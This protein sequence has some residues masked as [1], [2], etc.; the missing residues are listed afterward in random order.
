MKA[1]EAPKPDIAKPAESSPVESKPAESKSKAKILSLL[2][3]TLGNPLAP[4]FIT[5]FF[6]S[7]LIVWSICDHS[8]PL[9]DAS[10]HSTYSSAVKKW[11]LRPRIWS[12]ESLCE[13]LRMQPNYPA[14]TWFFNGFC[15]IFLGDSLFSEHLILAVHLCILNAASFCIANLLLKDRFKASLSIIFLDCSPLIQ[16]L[17]HLSYIDL[18]HTAFFASYLFSLIY[19]W[20]K[21]SWKSAFICGILFG[22]D[23]A[24]KQIAVLYS[25]P[26]LGVMALYLLYARQYRQLLQLML[27]GAFAPLF[28][29]SWVI[30]NW[31]SLT[32]YTHN[33]SALAYER[34]GFV[35]GLT[36]N[37]SM[38]FQQIVESFSPLASL[39]L[40]LTAFK[41]RR[42]GFEKLWIPV[43][44]ASAGVLLL[45]SV[46][47]FNLPEP[48]YFGPVVLALSLLLGV[49]CG[50]LARQS[51]KAAVFVSAF[52]ALLVTQT[53]VLS[54]QKCP[55][56]SHPV[57][58]NL[59]PLFAFAGLH[60][61][62]LTC[63]IP[64]L[65]AGDPWKQQ[66]LF[67]FIENTERKSR[68]VYLSVLDNSPE[69]NQGVLLCISRLRK[70]CVHPTT[71]RGCMPD[72]KDSFSC[73]DEALNSMQW[74]LLKTGPQHSAWFDDKSR[75]NYEHS[76]DKIKND[77]VYLEAARQLLP[78]GAELVLYQ[79]KRFMF[80]HDAAFLKTLK[81]R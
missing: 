76:V 79:N 41:I 32:N 58:K 61:P 56:V 8:L 55:V 14:G 70:S 60:D 27:I 57:P 62:A 37:L 51:G 31:N 24:C 74:I 53:L 3:K 26:V 49:A 35:Q 67:E 42:D 34:I 66:W 18:P 22:L 12:V 15:K 65:E 11:L 39:M 68:P 2:E 25:V 1:L 78:D 72:V 80:D 20:Q 36:R 73:S 38:S 9:H 64:Y 77:G 13:L 21:K 16:A 52:L 23:C 45:V 46:A 29:S 81:F 19:W 44:A 59:S 48:R 7:V 50:N 28:L 10:W 43:F 69:F 40:V 4:V 63:R 71:W 5:L 6:L 17:Q 54:F 47:F 30:P 33:R 75:E